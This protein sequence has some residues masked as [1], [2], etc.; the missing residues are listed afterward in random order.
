MRFHVTVDDTLTT[1]KDYLGVTSAKNGAPQA[2]F[3]TCSLPDLSVDVKTYKE[4]IWIYDRKFPGVPTVSDVT[5]SRGVTRNDTAFY[6]WLLKTAEG[7]G[8]YRAKISIKIYHRDTNLTLRDPASTINDATE[9][10]LNN[11]TLPARTITLYEAFP[12]KVT[13]GSA[14]DSA[15]SEISVAEL[16]LSCERFTITDGNANAAP[17][18]VTKT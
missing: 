3:K 10:G 1:D 11:L 18:T 5:M 6:R 2:G 15:N 4:G 17:N 9:P 7:T 12:T 14:L 13:L 16:T 8:E